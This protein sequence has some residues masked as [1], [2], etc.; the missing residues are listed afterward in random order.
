MFKRHGLP[1]WQFLALH[2]LVA[3]SLFALW[4]WLETGNRYLILGAVTAFY[5]ALCFALSGIYA[6]LA[7]CQMPKP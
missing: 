6:Q 3:L 5:G 4:G 7:K 1:L 2:F